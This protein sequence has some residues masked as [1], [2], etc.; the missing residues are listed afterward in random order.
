MSVIHSK[1]LYRQLVIVILVSIC[2]GCQVADQPVDNPY[3]RPVENSSTDNDSS[4]ESSADGDAAAQSTL[5]ATPQAVIQ[6]QNQAL[7]AINEDQYPLATDYLQRAI[8]IQ[9]RNAWSWHY[10]ADIHWRQGQH[11]RC[12]AMIERSEGYAGANTQ[13]DSENARLREQCQ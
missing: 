4:Q 8:K 7:A 1:T 12:I 13:L 9:P 11:E 3:Q 2:V 10:L 6:L 5:Q